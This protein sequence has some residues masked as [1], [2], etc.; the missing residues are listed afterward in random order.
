MIRLS[1]REPFA[2]G[3][4]RLCFVHPDDPGKC[5]KVLLPGILAKRR[6][7]APAWK[8]WFPKR[9]FD[10][11]QREYSAYQ[12]LERRNQQVLWRHIPKCFGWCETDLG[13][14]LVTELIRDRD[15]GIAQNL[16]KYLARHDFDQSVEQAVY[17]FI[18]FYKRYMPTSRDLLDHNMT[19]QVRDFD[20][21]LYLIDG[22]DGGRWHRRFGITAQ[23]QFKRKLRRFY[24]KMREKNGVDLEKIWHDRQFGNER[25]L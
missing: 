20:K 12:K 13:R 21:Q 22:F 2:K 11:N 17:E 5:I 25:G 9:H 3:G 16:R 7:K 4:N 24:K 18:C 19:I 23:A 14:G 6:G 15:G 10:D 1:D 8:A